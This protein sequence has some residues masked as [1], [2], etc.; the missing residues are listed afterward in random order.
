VDEKVS[1][2]SEFDQAADLIVFG[3]QV[4]YYQA[5]VDKLAVAVAQEAPFKLSIVQPKV[6][7]VQGG[8]MQLKVVA[9]RKAGFAAPITLAM[10]FNP[11]GVSAGG[12]T[13]AANAME[14]TLPLN[15]SS[16]AQT[17]KW[18]VC[19]IGSADRGGPLWV[20]T[21]LAE[22][23]VAT[24]FVAG[25]LEM[26]TAEQGKS[27]QVLCNLEQKRPFEGKA[28]VQL[29]GLPPNT[30]AGEKEINASDAKV[31]FDVQ[32]D[33]KSPVGS[34][35]SLFCTVTVTKEGEP[36]V[37]SIAGGGVLRIDPPPPAPVAAAAAV[38]PATSA[39]TTA[40]AAPLSRLQ[41]LRVEQ[42]ARSPQP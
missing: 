12:A 23:E 21:Q 1:V 38:A 36:I 26:A 37:Q 25:K 10:L 24:P 5:H 41:K 32:T 28:K 20:S 17:R 33:A 9:E 6:P 27:A 7:L 16:D 19:V 2:K 13:I 42:A 39:A 40:P 3:N 18:K 8:S 31:V 15:A 11:P 30:S 34:H 4:V 22:L 35:N 29:L 14:S